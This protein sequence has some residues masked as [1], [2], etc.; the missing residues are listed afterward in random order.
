[1]VR[2]VIDRS[3]K[4]EQCETQI[5]EVQVV[6]SMTRQPFNPAGKVIAEITDRSTEK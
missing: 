6:D 2:L 1:M 3:D 4:F 5:W